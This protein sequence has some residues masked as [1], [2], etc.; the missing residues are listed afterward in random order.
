MDMLAFLPSS[1][2]DGKGAG[3]I[4]DENCCNGE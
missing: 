4:V 2:A 1:S 3:Y